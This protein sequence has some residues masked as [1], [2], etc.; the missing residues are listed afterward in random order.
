L[1]G[2]GLG[3]AQAD[4]HKGLRFYDTWMQATPKISTI[5]EGYFP[6]VDEK[7]DHLLRSAGLA[8]AECSLVDWNSSHVAA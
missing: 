6:P 7:L 8:P 5:Q 3:V 2:L 4:D 1:I